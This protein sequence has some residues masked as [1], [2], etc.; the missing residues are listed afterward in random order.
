M[1]R[2]STR[3]V[4]TLTLIALFGLM[5]GGDTRADEDDLIT[6]GR[7]VSAGRIA[8]SLEAAMSKI[9]P[10]D[11]YYLGRAVAA[12][13]LTRYALFEDVETT[14]Y[15]NRVGHSLA[16]ASDLPLVYKAY[17]FIVLDDETVN[18]FAVPG[19]FVFITRGLLLLARDEDMLAAVL[20]HEIAHLEAHHGRHLIRKARWKKFWKVAVEN[21]LASL[22][23]KVIGALTA[24][25][26]AMTNDYFLT[27]LTKGYAKQLDLQA[28][29][30]ATALMQRV[31]YDPH[32]LADVIRVLAEVHDPKRRD[33]S[34]THPKPAERLR[35]L[36]RL[37]PEP[38]PRPPRRQQRFLD[39]QSQARRGAGVRTGS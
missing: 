9:T 26:G 29:A 38:I 4:P 36:E 1:G 33:L 13:I 3:A 35:K 11:E 19:A 25:L 31:G 34:H 16:L 12:R 39:V 32:A 24:T 5:A 23:P 8:F 7:A 37:A 30:A 10:E 21:A 22:S 2:E 14:A 15:V 27:L 18:A 20:A 17:H 28:D 6:L